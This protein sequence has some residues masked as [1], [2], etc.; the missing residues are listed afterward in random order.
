I[1]FTSGKQKEFFLLSLNRIFVTTFNPLTGLLDR[2]H[3]RKLQK[4]LHFRSV[5]PIFANSNHSV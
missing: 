2:V 1:G 3:L 4:N 5:H